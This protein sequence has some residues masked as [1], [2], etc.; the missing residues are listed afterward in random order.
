MC[1]LLGAASPWM[2][3]KEKVIF[4][5]LLYAGVFRGLDS[6][7]IARVNKKTGFK[8]REDEYKYSIYKKAIPSAALL[9]LKDYQEWERR[10]GVQVDAGSTKVL[11]GHNRAATLGEV[12]DRNAHP[13]QEGNIILAHNG[14]LWDMTN[15]DD[16]E[17]FDIDS[18]C[19]AYNV[20]KNGIE[21]TIS[22]L[23]GAFALSWIDL[24]RKTLNFTRNKERPF[25]IVTCK[26][27]SIFWASEEG[28]LEWIL[29]RNGIS[30][31]TS[32]ELAPGQHFE[33]D[34][35]QTGA[36]YSTFKT[37][38]Y[39]LDKSVKVYQKTT[40]YDNDR[41][42][43]DDKDNYGYQ[44]TRVEKKR[45]L[46]REKEWKKIDKEKSSLTDREYINNQLLRKNKVEPNKRIKVIP[47]D[48]EPY[49]SKSRSKEKGPFQQ[50][51]VI[52]GYIPDDPWM[53]IEI[54]RVL[55][56][57][58]NQSDGMDHIYTTPTTIRNDGTCDVVVCHGVIFISGVTDK[59]RGEKENLGGGIICLPDKSQEDRSMIYTSPY[60][61][62]ISE[63]EMMKLT[64]KGCTSCSG[65]IDKEE[66]DDV[67]WL[68][69][70]LPICG[71]CQI[72]LEV[73]DPGIVMRRATKL[74]GKDRRISTIH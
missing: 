22:K 11:M 2:N 3:D 54:H 10:W 73:T 71:E 64:N 38:E 47:F 18:Q 23:R 27:G 58:Y 72:E 67:Y 65:D 74:M 52:L 66:L 63:D 32:W 21:E 9:S 36:A 68:E 49:K 42:Y 15:L 44:E 25:A 5:Q 48:Y 46:K 30:Y 45:R 26:N 28:M 53:P 39:E 69:N 31:D 19:I 59:R 16:Y 24:E 60:G 61:V 29:S 55:Q 56:S 40:Y 37:Y 43:F 33:F 20:D 34:L 50:L 17:H 57:T 13:Y 14:T 12:N 8:G 41:M 62:I 6:T 4:K 35:T 7:G 51:G 70:G 1:G